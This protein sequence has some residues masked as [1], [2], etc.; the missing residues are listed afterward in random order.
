M[1]IF[2]KR[3]QIRFIQWLFPVLEKYCPP[4]AHWFACCLFLRP[5]RFPF[6]SLEKTAVRHSDEIYVSVAGRKIRVYSWGKG[7]YALFIHGWSGRGTNLCNFI[8]PIINAGGRLLAFDAPAH[9]KSEGARTNFLEFLE[10][11]RA[12][13]NE[14]GKPSAYIGHSLGGMAAYHWV[15]KHAFE[16]PVIMIGSPSEETDIFQTFFRRLHGKGTG[17]Q[18]LKEWV[19]KKTGFQFDRE[20]PL[21]ERP[22]RNPSKLLLIHDEDDIDC[23]V[24]D[25][26]KLHKANQGSEI[27]ITQGL[28][29]LAIL[30]DSQVIEKS[31]S[32][33]K[34]N[35]HLTER[36]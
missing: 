5:F 6:T 21:Y 24:E 1:P 9:G 33:L 31:L 18:K 11:M 28:G 3:T 25:S 36:I 23:S 4:A 26:K 29:H 34:K 14:F 8:E 12:I 22:L 20:L 2:K 7:P 32:F 27:M 15:E 35:Y 30:S 10:V 13:E 19:I 17:K 16:T